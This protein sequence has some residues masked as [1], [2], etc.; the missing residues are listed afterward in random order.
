M[1]FLCTEDLRGNLKR[2][3][4]K[5]ISGLHSKS[6][7]S[8]T[9]DLVMVAWAQL[10]RNSDSLSSGSRLFNET[11]NV[12]RKNFQALASAFLVLLGQS[13]SPQTPATA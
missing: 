11:F 9:Q 7:S 4:A 3:L 6:L 12:S 13:C 1:S 10:G 2:T 5:L 8:V